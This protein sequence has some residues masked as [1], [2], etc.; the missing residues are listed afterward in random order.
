MIKRIGVEARP[1]IE[2]LLEKRVF[3]ELWVKHD[4]NW[5]R[6]AKHAKALGYC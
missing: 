1:R 6:R 2:K 4:P 3:L 5:T